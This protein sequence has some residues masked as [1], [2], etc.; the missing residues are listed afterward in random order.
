MA[1][2]ARG[3]VFDPREVS[4][5]HCINRCVRACHLC[6]CD[7]LT[8]IDYDHR[9]L[10]IEQRLQ[11]L[12]G[13]FAI[14]V[15]GFAVMSNHFHVILRNRPDI[16]DGWSDTEVARR[17]WMLCPARKTDDGQPEEPTQAELEAI[18]SDPQRL[19]ELRR[20]L[21]DISWF[22][23]MVAEPIARLANAEDRCAG[24]F[25]QGRF[26]AVKLC[27]EAALLACSV[28]V[29]LNP[30]R[31]GCC[32]T[33]ETSQHTS[34]RQRIDQLQR[35]GD[36]VAKDGGAR[37]NCT[38]DWLAPLELDEKGTPGPQPSVLPT[39]ASDKGF[40]PM[41][42]EDYLELLDW[43]GRQT[44]AGKTGTIPPHLAPILQRLGI[45]PEGW[46]ELA[47]GFGR[48]F[49]RVAGSPASVAREATRRRGSHR[50]RNPGGRLLD[51][52]SRHA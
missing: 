17:W 22:M 18:R 52:A 26:K 46:Y 50:F 16:V 45:V 32:Q 34:A 13:Y 10:W 8:G 23:R 9:K 6:G 47:T 28:Y 29:D 42:V 7:P 24:R 31:A 20:R 38:G 1:R 36:E 19:A 48:L 41:S 43:T 5:L 37:R 27:D 30:L 25:W 33:P 15:L 44:V 14:D 11:F 40:L 51:A 2:V 21:S 39:R 3:E 49:H 12:A 4:V 35:I